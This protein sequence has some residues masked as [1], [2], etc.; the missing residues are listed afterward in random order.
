MTRVSFSVQPF[1]E[2]VPDSPPEADHPKPESVEP[3]AGFLELGFYVGG[4]RIVMQSIRAGAF[5]ELFDD[6]D[7]T[8]GKPA[9]GTT[10]SSTASEPTPDERDAKIADLEAKI[11]ELEQAQAAEPAEPPPAE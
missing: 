6:G 1:A 3:G 2:H 4:Q 7:P 5:T 11:A 9:D 8:S 10:A